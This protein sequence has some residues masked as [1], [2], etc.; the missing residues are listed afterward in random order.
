MR[1]ISLI[2]ALAIFIPLVLGQ[3]TAELPEPG[4]TPGDL[5][6]GLEKAQE[7][8]SLA[9]T[10]DREAKMEKKLRFADERLAESRH[11]AQKGDNQS[12]AKAAQRYSD[13][14]EEV[15]ATAVET[16]NED[17]QRQIS[18][19]LE[20][21]QEVLNDLREKLPEQTQNGIENAISRMPENTSNSSDRPDRGPP[22]SS[23]GGFM[24]TGGSMPVSQ[25]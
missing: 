7:S 19:H 23:T 4:K 1:K 17:V 10:F 3:S 11:L 20:N 8:I 6:Y 25:Q 2:V 15:N 22:R 18:Q 14:I 24:V 9:I 12:A 5:L 13:I 16:E 21:R